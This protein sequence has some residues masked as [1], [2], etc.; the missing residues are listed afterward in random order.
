MTALPVVRA[1]FATTVLEGLRNYTLRPGD[2]VFGITFLRDQT[3]VKGFANF[4]FGTVEFSLAAVQVNSLSM[5]LGA[6][7]YTEQW[8]EVQGG[9]KWAIVADFSLATKNLDIRKELKPETTDLVFT[10]DENPNFVRRWQGP[11]VFLNSNAVVN[12]AHRIAELRDICQVQFVPCFVDVPLDSAK[13]LCRLLC[14]QAGYHVSSL[15]SL[16]KDEKVVLNAQ[17]VSGL[18]FRRHDF[19]TGTLCNGKVKVTTLAPKR[20]AHDLWTMSDQIAADNTVHLGI[21]DVMNVPDNMMKTEAYLDDIKLTEQNGGYQI[22][23]DDL[24]KGQVLEIQFLDE[25]STVWGRVALDLTTD[26][27]GDAALSIFTTNPSAFSDRTPYVLLSLSFTVP[28]VRTV[29]GATSVAED[30]SEQVIDALN[31]SVRDALT[32]DIQDVPEKK[33]SD[34]PGSRPVLNLTIFDEESATHKIKAALRDYE[35]FAHVLAVKFGKL[36]GAFMRNIVLFE[37]KEVDVFSDEF[38]AQPVFKLKGNK[39]LEKATPQG[40]KIANNNE[41]IAKQG[42][43][44]WR[45]HRALSENTSFKWIQALRGE[46]DPK[47]SKV[48]AFEMGQETS[49]PCTV[50]IR[51]IF[52][53]PQTLE[54]REKKKINKKFPRFETLK[55]G[56]NNSKRKGEKADVWKVVTGDR[57]LTDLNVDTTYCRVTRIE[58]KS[59]D[60]RPAE[61]GEGGIDE[62]TKKKMSIDDINELLRSGKTPMV[63]ITYDRRLQFRATDKL[64][65]LAQNLK[66][67]QE[68]ITAVLES[69]TPGEGAVDESLL[70]EY[71]DPEDASVASKDS[72]GY[73][74][75]APS[76]A[77]DDER[78]NAVTKV[79]TQ[80]VNALRYEFFDPVAAVDDFVAAFQKQSD[81]AYKAALDDAIDPKKGGIAAL[82]DLNVVQNLTSEKK[83]LQKAYQTLTDGQMVEKRAYLHILLHAWSVRATLLKQAYFWGNTV[84]FVVDTEKLPHTV[85]GLLGLPQPKEGGKFPQAYGDYPQ[86][87]GS[88]H[89]D[90][91]TKTANRK[92]LDEATASEQMKTDHGNLIAILTNADQV[93][94]SPD[95]AKRALRLLFSDPEETTGNILEDIDKFID[96]DARCE[97][98]L[99]GDS[100][101]V[102]DEEAVTAETRN[103]TVVKREILGFANYSLFHDMC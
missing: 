70:Y 67:Y 47:G 53:V 96:L 51:D 16:T 90:R 50:K 85:P 52:D 49:F 73:L 15:G 57:T 64:E 75:V 56:P 44:W 27:I 7:Y 103:N 36:R 55:L 19:Q 48:Y 28:T 13:T 83:M 81:E 86:A 68:R 100:L 62:K 72:E 84:S 95:L 59:K 43:D 23:A 11:T 30:Q 92:S 79:L 89:T 87:Y 8:N 9:E 97:E 63:K 102:F 17:L 31:K 35:D 74:D 38:E 65:R 91:S 99:F 42:P 26:G 61:N 76:P 69:V 6:V 54:K 46:L 101:F 71:F 39:P 93:V 25:T 94:C 20:I 10:A 80:C 66:K 77:K 34:E 4:V 24:K 40:S 88:L 3:K 5:P 37:P 21:V 2:E 29:L 60:I 78:L 18:L 98:D 14:T 22:D 41:R 32:P 33:P 82:A 58:T 45:V 12:L 1:K